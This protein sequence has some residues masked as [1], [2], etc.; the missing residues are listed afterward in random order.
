MPTIYKYRYRSSNTWSAEIDFGQLILDNPSNPL[1][2]GK[3]R[4]SSA[5]FLAYAEGSQ[6]NGLGVTVDE[7]GSGAF[8]YV[9]ALFAADESM[10]GGGTA[11]GAWRFATRPDGSTV[12]IDPANAAASL[13]GYS[14][15]ANDIFI[16]DADGVFAT[17]SVHNG[18]AVVARVAN[19]NIATEGDWV[20]IDTQSE[21]LS[22][23]Q[24]L[25]LSTVTRT[26]TRFDFNKH[27]FVNP[28]NI[29][30][31][32]N[33]ATPGFAGQWTVTGADAT[34]QTIPLSFGNNNV[35]IFTDLVGGKLTLA[36]S[37]TT[38]RSGGSLPELLRLDFTYGSGP[39]TQVFSFPLDGV[40]VEGGTASVTITIPDDDYASILNDSPSVD[41][42]VN[43][44]G[45][46]FLGTVT[47]QPLVNSLVGSLHDDVVA[48]ARGE[49]VSVESRLSSAITALE[50]RES[51]YQT[52]VENSFAAVRPLISPVR[53]DLLS[54][55][56]E[57]DAYFLGDSTG[58]NPFPDVA[59]MVQVSP[60]NP[61]W[62]TPNAAF[63]VAVPVSNTVPNHSLREI[64]NPGS[65]I[66]LTT[67]SAQGSGALDLGSSQLVGT[68]SFAVYRVTGATPGDAYEVVHN[69]VTKG[70]AW[71]E[72]ID[73]LQSDVADIREKLDHPVLDLPPDVVSVLKNDITVVQ[74]PSTLSQP[75][76]YN[77][78]LGAGGTV[79]VLEESPATSPA[80][81]G[82]TSSNS[83]NESPAGTR[84]RKLVV[85][86]N[87]Q[88]NVGDVVL[89]TN[90][91]GG[92]TDTLRMG[93]GG[94]VSAIKLVPSQPAGETT[95][96]VAPLPANQVEHD[97]FT[98]PA[99][100]I[101]NG[102][103]VPE[104]DE[105]FFTRNIPNASVTLNIAY[106]GHAN[107]NVFGTNSTT[108]AGVG[109]GAEVATTFVLDDGGE[110]ATVEV[111]WYPS[112]NRIRVSV[113]ER[114][115]AGLPTIND[116]EVKLTYQETRV[117][118]ERPATTREVPI[119]N[120]GATGS[121]RAIMMKPS[122]DRS[123]GANPTIIV[124]GNL[125]EVDIGYN[126]DDRFQS[127]DSGNLEARGTDV[128]IYNVENS[129]NVTATLLREFES[130]ASLPNDGFFTDNHAHDS[131][132]T[133]DTQLAG[134]NAEGLPV[135][136]GLIDGSIITDPGTGK[137]YT[138]NGYDFFGQRLDLTEIV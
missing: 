106:R 84:G 19:A 125:G 14:V 97:W 17:R 136:L 28:S 63:F 34:Q 54:T 132:V 72:D 126:Y 5:D 38:V 45:F 118:P 16:F 85:F 57:T 129:I 90:Q 25:F 8:H 121:N 71:Q 99:L 105:L 86:H 24:A 78:G 61:T 21:A 120:F 31:Q 87:H 32:L 44:H 131:V 95:V 109:G 27:V 114:V 36:A 46:L 103:P 53:D 58:S 12:T 124:V 42:V 67:Q 7:G 94:V 88:L 92:A 55:P 100:L 113:T 47:I 40:S 81:G 52:G 76:P 119:A 56:E 77:L 11:T 35:L 93:T 110:V 15:Q 65:D 102:I 130:R 134:E 41:L 59:E 1:L 20:F 133:L 91:A 6:P 50:G 49:V 13:T 18:D 83:L 104:A 135:K 73:A 138:V 3:N 68:K 60:T 123:G 101:R 2:G 82:L 75:T 4:G 117:I 48:L 9:V 127:D 111:R 22:P 98:I 23:E 43:E 107:G 122:V 128:A 116:V 33:A 79:K 70:V 89:A 62:D 115:G 30:T 96:T 137:R 29:Q 64:S 51:D 66:A 26:G 39:T 108:L 112:T 80:S 10:A 37:F 69:T 74:D